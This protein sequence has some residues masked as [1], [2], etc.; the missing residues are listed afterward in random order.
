MRNDPL[1]LVVS[2][3][4]LLAVDKVAL[5]MKTTGEVRHMG[6][7]VP[8]FQTLQRGTSL[9]DGDFVV[10]GD[11]GLAIALFLDDK[12]QVKIRQNTETRIWGIRGEEAISKRLDLSYGTLKATVEKQVGEFTITTPTSVASVKGTEFWLISN[13]DSADIIISLTGFIDLTNLISERVH[14]I[15][16]GTVVESNVQGE[17]NVLVT[18]K[19][20]GEAS[21]GISAGRFTLS[22]ISILDGELGVQDLSGKVE[23]TGN[24]VL[25]G[26]DVEAG[27]VVT[28]TGI[29]D[30]Q[31]GNIEATLIEVSEPVTPPPATP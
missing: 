15:V 24:T 21:S 5:T 27:V 3:T 6:E 10:T 8:E 11:D 22:G 30:E 13:P 16:P 28:L 29:W 1:F 26:A 12:S 2:V 20:T 23:V 9:F 17:I 14:S 4:G 19:I 7:Q 31:T 18:V 25:E